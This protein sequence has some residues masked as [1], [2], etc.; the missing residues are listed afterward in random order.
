MTR[1]AKSHPV[2]ADYT[3]WTVELN[4]EELMIILDGIRS[5]RIKA[6]K[7]RIQ[8]LRARKYKRRS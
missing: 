1:K 8:H 4:R 7:L 3:V 2:T 6:A 5:H